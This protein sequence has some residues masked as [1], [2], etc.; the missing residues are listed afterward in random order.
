MKIQVIFEIDE[1]QYLKDQGV[2]TGEEFSIIESFEEL[3]SDKLN[4]PKWG[5][6]V[7]SV[8]EIKAVSDDEDDEDD[9][10]DEI[11]YDDDFSSEEEIPESVDDLLEF[12]VELG[13]KIDKDYGSDFAKHYADDDLPDGG[14]QDT[15]YAKRGERTFE[16]DI[17]FHTE[18]CGDWSVRANLAT[19]FTVLAVRET[20]KV[21]Q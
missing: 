15:I 12:F 13:Q 5:V 1:K 20:T 18:W 10:P 11:Y 21:E 16:I 17:E 3:V 7:D 8:K 19:G 4:K 2:E 6:S 14:W 9:K